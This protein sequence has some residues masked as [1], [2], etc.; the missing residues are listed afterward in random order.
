[1]KFCIT[2]ATCLCLSAGALVAAE[3]S[4]KLKQVKGLPE[5]FSPKIAAVLQETGY[6]V[7]GPDGVVC[8][9][10]PAKE[11]A[12]KPKFKPSLSVAYPFT[13]GQL[14]GAVQ[15]PEGTH[16]LDFRAQEIAAGVYTLRY[17]QQPEDGNHLGTSEI[18]DFCLALP[19]AHDKDPKPVFDQMHLTETSA[20]AAGTTHPAIF[21]MSAPPEKPEKETKLIHDEDHDFWIL[22]LAATG[23]AD[24]K[25]VP[26][27]VRVVVVGM[28]E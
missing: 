8:V 1:M 25:P 14:L 12:V 11:L 10:W 16:G 17:G 15:F 26:L 9:I 18:R 13:S 2:F 6:Q 20:E 7:T 24:D 4:H 3:P 28:G 5:G 23:K 21:L 27:S 19:A 22:Q